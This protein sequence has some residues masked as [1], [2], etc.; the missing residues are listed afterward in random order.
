MSAVESL[1]CRVFRD[2][3]RELVSSIQDPDSL[4]DDLFSRHLLGAG[5]MHELQVD[6]LSQRKKMRKILLA[7]QDQ[8]AVHPDKFGEFVEALRS[9]SSRDYLADKLMRACGKRELHRRG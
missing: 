3:Y 9:D 8:I 4:A 2:H 6:G 1:Q 7:V 5:M